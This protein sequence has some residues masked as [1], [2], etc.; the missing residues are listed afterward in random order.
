MNRKKITVGLLFL[1]GA[2][3]AYSGMYVLTNVIDPVRLGHIV[4]A[5]LIPTILVLLGIKELMNIQKTN[6]R[7]SEQA[8]AECLQRVNKKSEE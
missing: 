3:F 1:A 6:Q 2:S 4:G 8:N 5:L 7:K